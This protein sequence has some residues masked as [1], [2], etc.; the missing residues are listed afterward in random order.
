MTCEQAIDYIHSLEKFGINPGL[1]RIA[2][3]CDALGNPQDSLQFIHVAGTNGK[4]STSTMLAEILKAAGYKTGLFTSPYVI[5]FCERMQINGKMITHDELALIVSEIEPV[6]SALAAKGLQLTEFEAITAAAFLYFARKE[7]DIVVLE[8]GL[9]G[10]FDATN[11]IKTP[12]AS[13]ITSISMDHMAVLGNTIEKIAAEKCGIIK[14]N[15][16]TVCYPSQTP[17]ALAVIKA[18]AGQMNNELFIPNVEDIEMINE[19]LYGTQ[20]KFDGLS[21]FVPFMG[22]HMVLNASVAVATA[23]VLAQNGLSIS[24]EHIADGIA[25][26]KMPARMEIIKKEPLIIIDGGHNEGC[27]RALAECI[28]NH[29]KGR[30]IIAVCG[31]M[32]DKDYGVYLKTVAPLF[33]TLI[34]TKPFIARALDA[35][36]LLETAEK[37]CKNCMAIENTQDAVEKAVELSGKDD[38]IIICGSF[39]LAGEVRDRIK[40]L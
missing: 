29:L 13:V 10:R 33:K 38:V 12:L 28:K 35:K 24:D 6:I 11:L 18:T 30:K 2:A 4:G 7:C 31:M 25:A 8:V 22:A 20:V 23:R 3:L 36:T 40:Y 27:A 39:Y 32:S 5:D 37:Y 34:A 16:I 17:Q 9:G 15:G 21:V 26:A 14:Q 1:E 19:G